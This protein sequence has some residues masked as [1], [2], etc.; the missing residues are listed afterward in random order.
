VYY[1]FIKKLI[2]WLPDPTD[3]KKECD[4]PRKEVQIASYQMSEVRFFPAAKS[5]AKYPAPLP[6]G[7]Q[8]MQMLSTKVPNLTNY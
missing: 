4:P 8:E 6:A 5:P 1:L 2:F 3:K 7:K